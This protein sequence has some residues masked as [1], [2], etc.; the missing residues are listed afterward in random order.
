VQTTGKE[1]T[2]QHRNSVGWWWWKYF[3]HFSI[4]RVV[5]F[6]G[7]ILEKKNCLQQQQLLW[8]HTYISIW[9]VNGL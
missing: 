4:S 5:K 1:L 7:K 9:N 2:R 3:F 6:W 8:L